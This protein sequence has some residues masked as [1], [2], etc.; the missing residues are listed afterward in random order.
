MKL[1]LIRHADPDYVN[2]SLTPAGH[3]E[4]QALARRLAA[5][6]LTHL[7]TSPLG[8]ARMTAQYTAELL[9]LEPTAQD[10]MREF[11]GWHFDLEHDGKKTP[12]AAWNLP[13]E[14]MFLNPDSI[15]EWWERPEN[16]DRF[17]LLGAAS[18]VFLASYGYVRKKNIYRVEENSSDHVAMFCHNGFGLTWLAHL[19]NLPVLS[20]WTSF[21]L[22]PS[23]VTTITMDRRSEAWAAPRVLS[24]GDTSHLYESR[25]PIQRRGLYP[26]LD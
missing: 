6:P 19:L 7:Y 13:A 22:A 1:Y 4:A 23:S 25:L 11:D 2:D 5:I 26:M 17:S 8:R 24:T 12:L 3:L 20:V 18:D 9:K 15:T 14:W 10:W 21:W 16:Q